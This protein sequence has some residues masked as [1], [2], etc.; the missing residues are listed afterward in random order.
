MKGWGR[1]SGKEVQEDSQT[2]RILRNQ[3]RK[4]NGPLCQTLLKSHPGVGSLETG[5][6]MP[7]RDAPEW[8]D[9]VG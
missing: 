2:N 3:L 6:A 1:E 4:R 5:S 7:S 9:L 8:L